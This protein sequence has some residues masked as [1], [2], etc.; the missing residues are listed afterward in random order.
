MEK[1]LL[2]SKVPNIDLGKEKNGKKQEKE[3]IIRLKLLIDMLPIL[4][5]T[6]YRYECEYVSM[7]NDWY[8]DVYYGIKIF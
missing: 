8:H 3:Q 7:Q 2:S 1:I 5:I 4:T 6:T